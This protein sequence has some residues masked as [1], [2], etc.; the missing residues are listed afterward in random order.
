MA[1]VRSLISSS[2]LYFLN[3]S[4]GLE[5]CCCCWDVVDEVVKK[6]FCSWLHFP[7]NNR[8]IK[9]SI[10]LMMMSHPAQLLLHSP[11]ANVLIVYHSGGCF[12]SILF[13]F[14]F[15]YFHLLSISSLKNASEQT[16][17]VIRLYGK[18]LTLNT[19]APL[20]PRLYCIL[21]AVTMCRGLRQLLTTHIL[22]FNG[23]YVI[24]Y[25]SV[26]YLSKEM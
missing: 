3:F 1:F 16:V 5:G 22:Y 26:V 18:S 7:N 23:H 4:V 2:L 10:M 12:F 25:D 9:K 11:C 24:A 19:P 6:M 13:S 15:S 14:L 8:R 17:T 20:H 21:Y